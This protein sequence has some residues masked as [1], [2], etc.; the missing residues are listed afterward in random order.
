MWQFFPIHIYFFEVHMFCYFC[1]WTA[2][3]CLYILFVDIEI[4]CVHLW[5]FMM[6]D[7]CGVVESDEFIGFYCGIRKGDPVRLW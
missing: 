1:G 5:D 7:E 2:T 6:I 3:G 4:I